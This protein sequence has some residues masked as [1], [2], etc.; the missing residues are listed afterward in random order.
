MVAMQYYLQSLTEIK[1]TYRSFGEC[2]DD[3]D[4]N[5]IIGIEKRRSNRESHIDG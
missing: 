4:R 5:A 3:E 2:I 1:Q